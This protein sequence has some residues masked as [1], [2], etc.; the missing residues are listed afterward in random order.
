[1]HETASG[2]KARTAALIALIVSC[3]AVIAIYEFGAFQRFLNIALFRD[4]FQ[5]IVWEGIPFVVLGVALSAI[6]EVWVKADVMAGVLSDGLMGRLM[7]GLTGL[8]IPACDCGVVPLARG[9]RRKGVSESVAFTFV[10]SVPTVNWIAMAATFFA[11]HREWQWLLVR[12]GAALAISLV[13]GFVVRFGEEGLTE[14]VQT[15]IHLHDHG[16]SKWRSVIEHAQSELF[17]VGPF[18]AASAL[19]AGLVQGFTPLRAVTVFTH[20]SLWSIPLMMALGA[21]LSLCS[22][23]DAFVAIGLSTLFSPGAILA[24]LLAGQMIDLRNLVMMPKV[25]SRRTL[26]LG[27]TV[28]AIGIFAVAV[29]VNHLSF[30]K[31]LV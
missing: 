4:L 31:M 20:D 2:L 30:G 27:L 10:L 15:S 3:T 18:F 14:R 17:E 5:S 11:F 8:F 22:S 25:F 16:R 28:A 1:M 21:I 7:A 9:L 6:V 19:L 23:A 24:F 26:T 13:A 12:M 29:L